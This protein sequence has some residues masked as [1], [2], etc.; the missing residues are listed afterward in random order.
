MW[1][2][3]K[4]PNLG[5]AVGGDVYGNKGLIMATTDGG[6]TWFEQLPG[7]VPPQF[8]YQDVS[9]SGFAP[10]FPNATGITNAALNS[11]GVAEVNANLTL[12]PG[13]TYVPYWSCDGN[14]KA[15][16]IAYVPSP[17]L[18]YDVGFLSTA[19]WYPYVYGLSSISSTDSGDHAYAV[20]VMPDFEP[21]LRA[22]GAGYYANGTVNNSPYFLTAAAQTGSSVQTSQVLPVRCRCAARS[23]GA[24]VP[25]T[26]PVARRVSQGIYQYAAKSG[27]VAL[28]Y[29]V[30]Y[31]G[32]GTTASL[33]TATSTP[34]LADI[35][36]FGLTSVRRA[37][38]RSP[39]SPAPPAA[40]IF[41]ERRS[42]LLPRAAW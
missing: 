22:A 25:D 16:G 26:L 28:N 1:F 17:L 4:N 12:G 35:A 18:C 24:S 8:V 34:G 42:A 2:A 11:N 14:V 31:T 41:G 40:H 7:P 13:A 3:R 32:S 36:A 29:S 23:P 37:R 21:L 10:A 15:N 39:P 9:V 5:W 27:W 20:S 6:A 33:V 19:T 38:A 30:Y